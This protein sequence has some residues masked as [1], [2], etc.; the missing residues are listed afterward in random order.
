MDPGRVPIEAMH[1]EGHLAGMCTFGIFFKLMLS[2]HLPA[3][4]AE[5]DVGLV[6][7]M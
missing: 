7:F 2:Y 1:V 5:S 6:L 3:V 4:F